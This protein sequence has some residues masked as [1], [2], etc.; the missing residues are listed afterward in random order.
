[1]S[2]NLTPVV[3]D[4]THV[5]HDVA[6]VLSGLFRSVPRGKRKGMKLDITYQ[7][8][9]ETIR[10]L[11]YEPLGVDDLRVLQGL[12]GLAAIG[13]ENGRGILLPPEPATEDARQLRLALKTEFDAAHLDGI[14]V[15]NSFRNLARE[16][17]YKNP[18]SG[19]TL[20]SIRECIERMWSVSI[21]VEKEGRKQGFRLL[22]EYASDEKDGRLYVAL[23]PRITAA[24]TAGKGGQYYRIDM[25]EIRA[26]KSD[27]ARLIHQRLHYINP[28]ERRHVKI[29]TLASYVWPDK[30]E[31]NTLKKR[32]QTVR[33]ALLELAGLGWSVE[34]Y[35]PGKYTI[36]RPD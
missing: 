26:L 25:A 19:S 36:T 17:G 33:T 1:M 18:D 27:P 14:V 11:G 16:I 21:I 5:R 2:R 20:N 32:H 3:Y 12:I 29:D 15:K 8:Q 24:I 6:H 9:D 4:L 7:F 34:K 31:P 23:N 30:C 22:S 35:A 10:F 13:G 28:G